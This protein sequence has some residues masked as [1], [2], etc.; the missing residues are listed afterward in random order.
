MGGEDGDIYVGEKLG[1]FLLGF[2]G[3]EYIFF[4]DGSFKLVFKISDLYL[5]YVVVVVGDLCNCCW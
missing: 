1:N 2:Y 4:E 5:I 3:I